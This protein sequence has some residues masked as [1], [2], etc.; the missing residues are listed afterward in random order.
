MFHTLRL[1][2]KRTGAEEE[3]QATLEVDHWARSRLEFGKLKIG[4]I[5]DNYTCQDDS[6][7]VERMRPWGP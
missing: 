6:A 1:R 2:S 5:E 7:H 4:T 3:M